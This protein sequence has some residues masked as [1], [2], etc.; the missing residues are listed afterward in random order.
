MLNDV[1]LA[2]LLGLVP[3]YQ[4]WSVVTFSSVRTC[5]ESATPM[6]FCFSFD[7]ET[8]LEKLKNVPLSFPVLHVKRITIVVMHA[9]ALFI[10]LFIY[11][12]STNG[13]R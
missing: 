11:L 7:I 13:L 9:Y 3:V 5:F 10:Y 12:L 4:Q 6:P 1:F 8:S 2:G